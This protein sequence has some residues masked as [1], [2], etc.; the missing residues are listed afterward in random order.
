MSYDDRSRKLKII[1]KNSY[2]M[3]SLFTKM[4]TKK[5]IIKIY[6]FPVSTE[7]RNIKLTLSHSHAYFD[8][9]VVVAWSSVLSSH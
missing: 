9:L 4:K 1:G 8:G 3:V 6:E 7:D 5:A 2:I